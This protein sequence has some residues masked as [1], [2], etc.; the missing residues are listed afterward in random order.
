MNLHSAF[1]T[2]RWL[3][4]DT[5]RQAVASRVSWLILLV[6]A[7]AVLFCLSVGVTG[8]D[9]KPGARGG[10]SEYIPPWEAKKKDP[11]IVKTS[12]VMV[13]TGK[14]TLLFGALEIPLSRDRGRAVRYLEMLLVIGVADTAGLLLILVFTSSFLPS[15]LDPS[16]ATVLLAKPVPR[17]SL[18]A[19]KFIGVLLWVLVQVM[20][21]VFGT[22]LA[23]AVKTGVW[24]PIYLLCIPV[25]FVHFAVF[26]SFS[27]FL[28]VWTRSAVACVFG[29]ILFWFLCWGM[30]Y[31]HHALLAR[32]FDLPLARLKT[33]QFLVLGT[34][35]E[36]GL[37]GAVAWP[38]LQLISRA[39]RDPAELAGPGTSWVADVG[40]WLLPKPADLGIVLFDA[41]DASKVISQ[42][43]EYETLKRHNAFHPGMAITTSLIFTLLMLALAGY[44]FVHQDY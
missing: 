35:P 38:G 14:L 5:F 26:Y 27:T 7:V 22:W 13:T 44:E 10:G 8:D 40:Y 9:P 20:L 43:G 41:L 24:D 30:N 25:V 28:A 6:I 2:I 36:A 37:P 4:R 18:L 23:L 12:P 31:G 34:A 42:M 15:F 33:E 3:V 19:G 21:F 39:G 29:S 17:W 11:F 1:L 16:S 32:Q